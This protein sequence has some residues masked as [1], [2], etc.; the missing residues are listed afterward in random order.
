[1]MA[2]DE[3]RVVEDKL[4]RIR[5]DDVELE[6]NLDIPRGAQ[7]LVVFVHGSGSSRHSSRNRYVA[8]T[9]NEGQVGT[10]LFDLLTSA[11]EEIDNR[12]RHLRF[13]IELLARRTV[14]TVDWLVQQE[15][16][17]GMKMGLFGSSTGAAAA[18]IAAAERPAIVEAVV[19]RGGR[20]DL[21]EPV[22]PHVVTPT[23]LIVGE[24]DT[25]VIGMN[26]DALEK[27]PDETEAVLKL[28]PGAS[29]LF[30][31]SGTLEQAARL[32]RDWFV[33]HLGGLVS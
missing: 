6:G 8:R 9:L 32:A 18:L 4:V 15:F 11:E 31:E 23:L 22:L 17:E 33:Q 28:I 25:P 2:K 24:L 14:G 10:L 27:M 20:P 13:D 29:H 12:T 5:T 26:R 3:T 7:G 21:A 30:E 1:M 16:S 19:S